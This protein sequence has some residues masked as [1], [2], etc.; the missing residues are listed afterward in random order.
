MYSFAHLSRLCQATG[1]PIC[2]VKADFQI[3]RLLRK[4]G[5]SSLNVLNC[6][7]LGVEMVVVRVLTL[8]PFFCSRQ[9]RQHEAVESVNSCICRVDNIATLLHLD[10]VGLDI[11]WTA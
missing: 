11:D 8:T 9:R 10:I 4:L 7:P 3:R 1:T 2:H 6:G 5:I